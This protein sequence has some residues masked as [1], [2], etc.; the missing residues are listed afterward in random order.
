MYT[1]KR[2][3]PKKRRL[4]ALALLLCLLL[5]GFGLRAAWRGAQAALQAQ[6]AQSVRSAVVA[7]AVQ[8][9][10]LEGA[11][12]VSLAYLEENYGLRVNHA[13]F[14]ISYEAYASNLLPEIQVLARP[15]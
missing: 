11:Y 6:A 9:Y 4:E 10:A 3:S 15:G 1:E 5:G 8:C 12:P 7:A 13:S 14:I 2:V